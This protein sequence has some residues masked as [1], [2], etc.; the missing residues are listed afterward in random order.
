MANDKTAKDPVVNDGVINLSKPYDFE[1]STYYTVDLSKLEDLTGVELI[2]ADRY[3]NRTSGF[4][5]V[6]E[7]TPEYAYYIASKVSG[8][9]VEFFNGLPL[10]DSVKIK[11][12]ITNFTY[13]ED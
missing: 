8:L 9:P 5:A 4:S 7:I 10:K 11:N 13:G 6:P 2:E 12:R 3:V 1:G